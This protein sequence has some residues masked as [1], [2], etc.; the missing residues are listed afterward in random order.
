LHASRNNYPVAFYGRTGGYLGGFR[1][2]TALASDSFTTA[3]M[4]G[5]ATMLPVVMGTL[6]FKRPWAGYLLLIV[7]IAALESG[8]FQQ[9]RIDATIGVILSLIPILAIPRGGLL[10]LVT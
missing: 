6:T 10:A 1:A 5:A 3:L 2:I 8:N 4:L 9:N 7:A